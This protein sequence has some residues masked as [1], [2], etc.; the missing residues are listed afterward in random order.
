MTA[1]HTP[2][3]VMLFN[4]EVSDT[5]VSFMYARRERN[6]NPAQEYGDVTKQT[7]DEVS[8]DSPSGCVQTRGLR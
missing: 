8:E 2:H 5:K 4:A 3:I 6:W 7:I 1:R